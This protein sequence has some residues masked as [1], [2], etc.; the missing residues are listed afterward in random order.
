MQSVD[1][2]PDSVSKEELIQYRSNLHMVVVML[3]LAVVV[4]VSG[5]WR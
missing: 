1:N 3:L 5:G 2:A 4:G